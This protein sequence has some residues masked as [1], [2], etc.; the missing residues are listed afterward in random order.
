MIC[1]KKSIQ[2]LSQNIEEWRRHSLVIKLPNV[3][4]EGYV[5]LNKYMNE[6]TKF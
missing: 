1:F 4:A 6:A 5:V 3:T 2:L